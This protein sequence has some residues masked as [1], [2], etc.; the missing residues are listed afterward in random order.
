[1]KKEAIILAGGLGTRLQHTVPDV[2]KCLAPVAGRPF[3][4]YVI[5]HLRKA[6]I[7]KFVFSLGYKHEKILSFLNEYFYSLPF[8]Y[9]V[10]EKPLGTGGALKR[11]ISA[12][13]ERHVIAANGDTLFKASLDN[14]FAFHIKNKACS[15][16]LLKP[17]RE[18]S[19]YGV[20]ELHENGRITGFREKQYYESGLINAGIYVL[21]KEMFETLP[22]PEVFS[23]EK[24][25]LEAY[26]KTLPFYGMPSDDYFIDIGVPEDYFRAQNELAR[27][28]LSRVKID[29]SWTLFLDRDG[30]INH[31]IPGDYIRNL[32]QFR[33]YEN[34]AETINLLSSVFGRIFIVTNQRGVGKGLMTEKDLN[35][36]HQSLLNEINRAGGRIDKIYTCTATEDL[37]PERKPNPGMA[38]LAKAEFPEIEFSR[39]VMVGNRFS[40]MLFAAN[41][42]MYGIFLT[43]TERFPS[44]KEHFIDLSFSSLTEFAEFVLKNN[45]K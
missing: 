20:V 2:P 11:A 30:V 12:C 17:M 24:D 13:S 7:E 39:S 40:D 18:I 45:T 22:L 25:V 6:G 1:M 34:M 8:S 10:E 14:A 35:E 4:F 32:S 16:L 9:V 3:L 33:L 26:V 23:F 43:T 21:D 15:T 36:I 42:G 27:P 29:K 19:R 37:H 44:G 41:A 31:D 5:N 28:P 38:F